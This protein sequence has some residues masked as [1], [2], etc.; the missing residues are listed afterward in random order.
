MILNVEKRKNI[1]KSRE[2]PIERVKSIFVSEALSSSSGGRHEVRPVEVRGCLSVA[3]LCY[4]VHAR[5]CPLPSA[6]LLLASSP[7]RVFPFS[8]RMCSSHS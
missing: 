5:P 1:N 2:H 3:L 6:A 4:I 7:A 8:M